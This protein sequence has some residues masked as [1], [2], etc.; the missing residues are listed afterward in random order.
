M[1]KIDISST[2]I[3]KGLDLIKGFL[4]KL[5]GGTIEEAGLMFADKIRLRRLKNQ[6]TILSKAQKIATD[7]NIDVKQINYKILV[8]LLEYASLE[9]EES[10]QDKWACLIS[11]YAD[12]KQ[13]YKNAI[14]PF[15]LNQITLED[16]QY[17]TA[18]SG[19]KKRKYSQAE[20]SQI[21]VA[22]LVRLGLIERSS[23]AGYIYEENE[24]RPTYYGITEI[25]REL[26]K[27]CNIPSI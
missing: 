4:E 5:A 25:G 24:E 7:A 14:F 17:V 21:T 3:E 16:I 6:I 18:I 10:L 11:N 20:A 12:S 15:I 26:L 23:T 22:N 13:Q 2:F 9:E 27:V 8:P 1:T 19:F